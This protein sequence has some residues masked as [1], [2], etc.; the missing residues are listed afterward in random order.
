M[1]L[2]SSIMST[3]RRLPRRPT[4]V[5]AIHT[6]FA[7]SLLACGSQEREPLV[8]APPSPPEVH[9]SADA[10]LMDAQ[11]ARAITGYWQSDKTTQ[12]GLGRM[13]H[14][15]K[16]GS[17]AERVIVIVDGTFVQTG[18]TVTVEVNGEREE[19]VTRPSAVGMLRRS[20][21]GQE[22][23]LRPYSGR[24]TAER[25]GIRGVW[26]Y[27]HYSG[28]TAYERYGD[29]GTWGLRIPLGVWVRKGQWSSSAPGQ[30][31]CTRGDGTSI[32]VLL[33][34]LAEG[35]MGLRVPSGDGYR[36]VGETTWYPL[37]Q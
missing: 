36:F 26:S 28:R 9:D 3:V 32:T 5:L 13:L 34:E 18:P 35:G 24:A 17:W 2:R 23:T 4:A 29:D 30:V 6:L 16:D 21:Q 12:G 27:A 22:V 31:V 20:A 10:A 8:H 15:D 25:D 19:F 14:F 37:A 11:H 1:A 33:D 7:V